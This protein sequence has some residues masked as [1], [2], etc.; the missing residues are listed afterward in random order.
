MWEFSFFGKVKDLNVWLVAYTNCKM[1][2]CIDRFLSARCH[3]L[4]GCHPHISHNVGQIQNINTSIMYNG[5]SHCIYIRISNNPGN[6]F[7]KISLKIIFTE[8]VFR[9]TKFPLLLKSNCSFGQIII[10]IHIFRCY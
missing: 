5:S 2:K 10:D 3:A 4:K 8:I 1:V 9:E 6:I 7:T